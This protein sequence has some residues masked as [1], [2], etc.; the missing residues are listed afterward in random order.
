MGQDTS[1]EKSQAL[2]FLVDV[3][4]SKKM[5]TATQLI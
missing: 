2:N 5:L 3:T 1:L 4:I